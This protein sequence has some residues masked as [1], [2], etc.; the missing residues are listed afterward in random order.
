MAST[1]LMQVFVTV[2]EAGSFA[3]TA[4]RLAVSPSIISKQMATLERQ[5]GARLVNRTTRAMVITE[6]G[7][8]YYEWC[9]KFL[10]T[11]EAVEEEVA[12]LQGTAR[13]HLN[14][15]VPHS[16]GILHL[17]RLITAFC[18]DYPGITTSVFTD[19]FPAPSFEMDRRTD[20]VLHLGPVTSPGLAARELT[21]VVWELFASPAYLRLHG[22]PRAPEELQKHNCLVHLSVFGDGRWR[23]SGPDGETVT[24]VAGT[25]TAN[26][27]MILTDAVKDG[28]G[29][30]LLPSFCTHEGVRDGSLVR[31]L[32]DHVGP[33]RHLYAVYQADRMMPQRMRLFIDFMVARLRRPPWGTV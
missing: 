30:S 7:E 31:V 8:H 29:I 32:P 14:I 22:A 28:I 26:S 25:V 3:A 5:L 19:D 11:M 10:A 21:Q 12:C 1:K 15:R 4:E 23:L 9:K 20:V 18:S 27:V 17:G 16:I 2:V 33:H 24:Q 13:G 6:I